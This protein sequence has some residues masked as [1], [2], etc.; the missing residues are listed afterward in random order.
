MTAIPIAHETVSYGILAI[1]DE[2]VNAFVD[3]D[4]ENLERLGASVGHAITA[5]ERKNALVSNTA[6]QLTFSHEGPTEPLVPTE[7]DDWA[8]EFQRLVQRDTGIL[9]YGTADGIAED[10][11]RDAVAESTVF[12]DLRVLSPG[13]DEY[14][15][16]VATSWGR[17]L[18]PALAEHGG[19]V[20]AVSVVDGECEFVVEVPP[21]R[22]KHQLVELVTDHYPDATL[23]AQETVARDEPGIANVYSAFEDR[24]TAK[25]RA[26]LETAFH[27]GYFDWPRRSTGEEIADRLGVTQATFSEH[28]RAA[29][30]TL[31]EAVFGADTNDDEMPTSPWQ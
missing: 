17:R 28:F 15:I 24:L 27:S 18:V 29:E 8:L 20:T 19:L 11:L 30:R 10:E 26:V 2:S 23:R 1:Y 31:F 22:D 14:E 3:P 12:E 13:P 4:P 6:L 21:G 25:Q 16:E 5:V 7:A 9:A